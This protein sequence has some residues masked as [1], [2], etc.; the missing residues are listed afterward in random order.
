MKIAIYWIQKDRGGVDTQLLSLLQ[1][2]PDKKNQFLIFVNE[3]ND[4]YQSIENELN[5][6]ENVE[7]VIIR[8]EWGK[9][10]GLIKLLKFVFFPIYFYY[11]YFLVKSELRRYDISHL[12][13]QNGGYPG[14]WKALSS[15]WAASSL[16]IKKRVLLIHH[17]AV[18][19]NIIH[20]PGEKLVDY[21]MSQWATDLVTVS[22][23]TRRTLIDYRGWDP[24]KNPIR[25]VHNGFTINRSKVKKSDVIDIRLVYH[26]PQSSYIIG[27]VGRIERYKGHED[28]LISMSELSEK[29]QS[30]YTIFIVGVEGEKG[31]VNRLNT[32]ADKLNLTCNL[33]FSGFINVNISNII[34]QFDILA[35]LTKDFEGFGLTIG[36]AMV[37]NVPV[38]CTDVGAVREFVNN[39]VATIIYPEDPGSL[40]DVLYEYNQSTEEFIHKAILAGEY[41]TKWN[42]EIMANLYHRLMMLE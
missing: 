14:S 31:E 21:M 41:I 28:L 17:G 12:L 24:Y 30:T 40:A 15:L 32:L 34:S 11:L 6:L 3:D 9:H 18:H 27:M 8:P 10:N 20:R 33:I 42:V 35:M 29:I 2:W 5:Q 16:R 19:G 38:I 39:K 26:I 25:V 4:G 22:H 37:C 36:E 13:V 23:A 7:M 1:N